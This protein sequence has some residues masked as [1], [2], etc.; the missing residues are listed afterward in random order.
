MQLL[1]FKTGINSKEKVNAMMTLFNK[2]IKI[3]E[4][5]IDLEDIDNVLRIE[6][7][8]N[9]SENDVMTIVRAEGYDIEILTD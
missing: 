2:N 5:S 4:W 9:L 6:A 3:L 1:L 7:T 8:A